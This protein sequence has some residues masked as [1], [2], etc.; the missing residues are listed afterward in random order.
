MVSPK[1]APQGAREHP[2]RGAPAE[3]GLEGGGQRCA[4]HEGGE[5]RCGETRGLTKPIRLDGGEWS[6]PDPAKRRPVRTRP[7]DILMRRPASKSCKPGPAGIAGRTRAWKRRCEP[8]RLDHRAGVGPP[9]PRAAGDDRVRR[10]HRQG[11]A[12]KRQTVI[13]QTRA[14][15]GQE[16]VGVRR[17]GGRVDEPRER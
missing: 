2:R 8:E 14:E 3:I 17:S 9:Q 11:T 5:R 6:R 12:G 7:D 15:V 1:S 13:D 4:S 10:G 16:P